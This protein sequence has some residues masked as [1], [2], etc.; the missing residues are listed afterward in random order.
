M[1][2]KSKVPVSCPYPVLLIPMQDGKWEAICL[3]YGI[4]TQGESFEDAGNMLAKAIREVYEEAYATGSL[5]N[6]VP[7]P[8]ELW[9]RWAAISEGGKWTKNYFNPTTAIAAYIMVSKGLPGLDWIFDWRAY[10]FICSNILLFISQHFE[11][12]HYLGIIGIILSIIFLTS[13]L[14]D[15]WVI[16]SNKR[17]LLSISLIHLKME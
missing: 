2:Y 9:H 14:P 12:L 11:S 13:I 1:R 6:L 5:Y 16:I 10:V 4:I 3:T 8:S 7:S 17:P 15:I